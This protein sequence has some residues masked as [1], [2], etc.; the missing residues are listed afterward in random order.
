MLNVF[1]S[2]PGILSLYNRFV[3]IGYSLF[4]EDKASD[5]MPDMQQGH[6]GLKHDLNICDKK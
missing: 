4:I 3:S 6:A 1:C 5:Q 2:Q